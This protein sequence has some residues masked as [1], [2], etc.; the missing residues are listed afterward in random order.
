MLLWHKIL[1]RS[2][3]NATAIVESLFLGCRG[4]LSLGYY[5]FLSFSFLPRHPFYLS[6]KEQ[7]SMETCFFLKNV[8]QYREHCKEKKPGSQQHTQSTTDVQHDDNFSNTTRSMAVDFL[9]LREHGNQGGTGGGGFE[10]RR[11]LSLCM[12]CYAFSSLSRRPINEITPSRRVVGNYELNIS[13]RECLF[14]SCIPSHCT[15]AVTVLSN[16]SFLAVILLMHFNRAWDAAGNI[17]HS[18]NNES[19]SETVLR[20]C[21]SFTTWFRHSFID[22]LTPG[23]ESE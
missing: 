23:S 18:Q 1:F 3:G 17:F 20:R 6:R 10:R 2:L 21:E 12:P 5:L 14:L 8:L 16:L 9:M 11:S 7:R 13:G 15:A 4:T 22:L 19:E